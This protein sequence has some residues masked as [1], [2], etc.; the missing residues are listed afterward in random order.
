MTAWEIYWLLKLDDIHAML[1][2]LIVAGGLTSIAMGVWWLFVHD[3]CM[4]ES[5]KRAKRAST[6]VLKIA[7]PALIVSFLVGT[8]LPT[9]KQMAA[10]LVVPTVVNN[11]RVQQLPEKVLELVEKK[12]DE[13]KG[14]ERASDD[15]EDE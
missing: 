14:R 11:E 5:D 4:G 6:S 15:S 7:I 1:G 2:I 13:L 8:F 12:L 3:E 10:V 9:T